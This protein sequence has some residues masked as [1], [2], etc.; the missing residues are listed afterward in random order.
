MYFIIVSYRNKLHQVN[1]METC[2]RT[3]T[4]SLPGGL[5]Y[6]DTATFDQHPNPA[7]RFIYRGTS[8][9]RNSPPPQD[10]YRTLGIDS[11]ASGS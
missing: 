9:T 4:R 8:L 2:M 1:R 10:H 3:Y 11:P 6:V 7:P 5:P